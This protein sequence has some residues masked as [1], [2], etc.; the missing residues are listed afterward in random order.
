MLNFKVHKLLAPNPKET[1]MAKSTD[2]NSFRFRVE[3]QIMLGYKFMPTF[4]GVITFSFILGTL[5]VVFGIIT[6][7]FSSDV[8]EIT[9]IYD[10]ISIDEACGYPCNF[11]V[12]SPLKAPVY[13]YYQMDN[14][15]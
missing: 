6:L 15:Y 1:R 5:L 10:S 7:I 12:A 2:P 13:L 3:Q 8:T 4:S 9:L 14:Y 11:W